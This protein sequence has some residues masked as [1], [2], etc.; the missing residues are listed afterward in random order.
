[1][2]GPMLATM[3]LEAG[4]NLHSQYQGLL[5]HFQYVIGNRGSPST[6]RGLP[7]VE[8]LYDRRLLP[9][10]VYVSLIYIFFYFCFFCE[11]GVRSSRRYLAK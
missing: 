4:Y 6:T 3:L 10:G 7:H 1:M 5:F 8:K 2:T 11:S 9:T